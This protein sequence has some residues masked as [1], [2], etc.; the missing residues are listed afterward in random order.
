M[1]NLNTRTESILR[2]LVR[3]EAGPALRKVLNKTRPEDVAAAMSH[4][5][6]TEQ[7]RLYTIIEDQ[8]YAAEVLSN[9]P[10]DAVREVTR[11]MTGEQVVALLDL[12]EADD[13]TD[14]VEILP[15]K[16]RE[17]VLREMVDDPDDEVT[18]LLAWP[19]DSA[20]GIMSPDVFT[21]PQ[22]A[23]TGE[24]IRT[25][26]RSHEDFPT[27]Y[28]LY[29]VDGGERLVGVVSLRSLLTHPEH[30]P[31]VSIMNRDVITVEPF[32]DQEE[33]ARYVA[34]YDL[35]AVPVVDQ[36]QHVLG[37]V[38]VDDVVDVIRE[39][40]AEDMMLMAGVHGHGGEDLDH[41]GRS[42]VEMTR[43][44]AGWLLATA[45][46]GIVADRI[47]HVFSGSLPVE[48]LAGLIPVVMGMGGNVGIQSTTLA[49][50]GLATGAVQV[51]GATSFIVREAKVGLMLGVLYG[52]LLGGYGFASGWPDPYVGLTV[53]VSVFLAIGIGS[54]LGSSLPVGLSRLGVDP[55]IATG[56]FVTTAVDILGIGLYFSVARLLLPG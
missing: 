10:E 13:A 43:M 56:P 12:M 17:R 27:F 33:V 1:A 25:L 53:G 5:T 35:L 9:L 31:L 49:V 24:A 37:L 41:S 4:L 46:G 20:G 26:Q 14:V 38:T 29:V 47:T 55:A 36:T 48:V 45:F 19:S 18:S 42:A 22:S 32:Q 54:L 40:A 6:G 7:R 2:R 34:R 51:K 52:V 21:M 8:E 50:R 23:T 28:Y 15:G 11:E 16:L 3:R 39:E 44:R 30:T